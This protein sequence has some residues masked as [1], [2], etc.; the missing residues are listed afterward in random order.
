MDLGHSG[1]TGSPQ[2]YLGEQGLQ[3]PLLNISTTHLGKKHCQQGKIINAHHCLFVERAALD[4]NPSRG[5]T[6]LKKKISERLFILS[7]L[8]VCLSW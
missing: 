6:W 4:S 5:A 2:V 1:H 3:I 7:T 8:P